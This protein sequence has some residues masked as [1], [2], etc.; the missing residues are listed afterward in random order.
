MFENGD[1]RNNVVP[2]KVAEV[3]AQHKTFFITN[4]FSVGDGFV[5][6]SYNRNTLK[7]NKP[8][9]SIQF[10]RHSGCSGS[11]QLVFPMQTNLTT[12]RAPFLTNLKPS[13]IIKAPSVRPAFV[14]FFLS[15]KPNSIIL[16]LAGTKQ[17]LAK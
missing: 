6:L 15:A 2:G 11:N 9:H 17:I 1:P 5:G 14:H 13:C 7:A 12:T 16:T 8:F 4:I 10:T 3:I